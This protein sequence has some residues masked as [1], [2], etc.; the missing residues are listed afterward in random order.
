MNK[1]GIQG[2]MKGRQKRTGE[3]QDGMP[4]TDPVTHAYPPPPAVSRRDPSAIQGC[5]TWTEMRLR[6]RKVTVEKMERRSST[7][8]VVATRQPGAGGW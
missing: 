2:L 7:N 5:G 1:S 3:S 4:I 6:A 8:S